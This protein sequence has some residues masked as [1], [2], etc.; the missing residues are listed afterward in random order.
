MVCVLPWRCLRPHSRLRLWPPWQLAPR[1]CFCLPNQAISYRPIAWLPLCQT[2]QVRNTS[3]SRSARP[4]HAL[5]LLDC[6][7]FGLKCRIRSTRWTAPVSCPAVC[8]SSGSPRDRRSHTLSEICSFFFEFSKL[9]IRNALI[10]PLANLSLSAVANLSGWASLLFFPCCFGSYS[11]RYSRR[12]E[13]R[14]SRY[15]HPRFK[16]VS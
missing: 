12:T 7:N 16:P 3:T 6:S 2:I 14:W 8:L 4:V 13:N 15:Y 5:S 11:W 1:L 9:S 10:S